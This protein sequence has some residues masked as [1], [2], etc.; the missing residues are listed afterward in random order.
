MLLILIKLK[1]GAVDADKIKAGSISG[2][3]LNV[4]S[5]SSISAKIGT[6]RTATTGART[7]IRDNLIEIYDEN[8]RLRVRMGVWK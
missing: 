8:N 2:D 1:T 3:K 6:L 5:L 4:N 7:E